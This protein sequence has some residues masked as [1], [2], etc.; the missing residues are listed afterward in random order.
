MNNSITL[1]FLSIAFIAFVGLFLAGNEVAK[2]LLLFLFV[3]FSAIAS[4]TL[5]LKK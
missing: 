4:A 3:A 5:T 1:I 2:T